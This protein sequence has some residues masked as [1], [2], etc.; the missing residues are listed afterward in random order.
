M[1]TCFKRYDVDGDGVLTKND[2][3][4]LAEN[5]IKTGNFSGSRADDIRNNYM[6]LWNTYLKP[7]TGD[8]SSTCEDFLANVKSR[9]KTVL[10]S[11]AIKQF[12][13]FFDAID[14]NRDDAIQLEEFINF[15]KAIG[16]TAEIAKEAF[17]E[18]DLNHDGVLSREEFIS[19][20]EDFCLLEEPSLPSDLFYGHLE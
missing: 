19:A 6:E 12:S 16:S 4:V 1:R 5:V 18:L 15:F 14:T 8:T 7:E 11:V 9:G 2:Y 20:G 17:K 3:A 10:E 13:L